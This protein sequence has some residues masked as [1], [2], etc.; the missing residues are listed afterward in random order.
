VEELQQRYKNASKITAGVIFGS[1]D[2]ILGEYARDKVIHRQKNREEK[3]TA[4]ANKKKT[5][6]TKL[7]NQYKRI[8]VNMS[9]QRFKWTIAKLNIA[10]K[11]KQLQG[12][13]MPKGKEAP[14]T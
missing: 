1:G 11:C 5:E 14:L 9:K 8:K 13:S 3:D 12:E 4:A 7:I 10:I 6:L 2:G